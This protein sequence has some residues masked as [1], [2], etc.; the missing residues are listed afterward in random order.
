M[1][2]PLAVWLSKHPW[3]AAILAACLGVLSFAF[4]P[5]VIVVS[6]I[7]ALIVLEQGYFLAAQAMLFSGAAIIAMLMLM[8][9][10]GDALGYG[11]GYATIFLVLPMFLSDLL[12]RTGSLNLVFQL[13]L[14]IGF[15]SLALVYVLL[16]NPSAFW[17]P[18]INQA[19]DILIENGVRVDKSL[20]HMWADR[21]WGVV[22]SGVTFLVLCGVFLGRWWQSLIHSHG[23]F[24]REFRRLSS[25]VVLG[26]LQFLLLLVALFVDVEWM[27]DMSRVA[28]LGLTLQGLAAAHRSK[29]EGWL[30][31]G[32]LRVIYVLLL[33]PLISDITV[34]FLAGWGFAVF[35]RRMRSTGLRV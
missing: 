15:V 20:A 12:R 5:L 31:V 35:W 7:I 4:P 2:L 13:L 14:L 33:L 27:K 6:A 26:S 25:G 16:P 28:L 29:A 24:G 17:E 30:P 21:F 1:H 11:I 10:K 22:I 8:W 34:L 9:P 32:W 18:S 3:Q 19:Y 23:A